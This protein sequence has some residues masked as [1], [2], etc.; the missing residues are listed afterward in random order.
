MTQQRL[1][2]IEVLRLSS[3]P[4]AL[5]VNDLPESRLECIS[6]LYRLGLISSDTHLALSVAT[7][8]DWDSF[9]NGIKG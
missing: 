7:I 8:K 1:I 3:A 5:G 4:G 9:E 6:M 2:E